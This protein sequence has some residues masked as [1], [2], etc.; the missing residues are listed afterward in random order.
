[1]KLLTKIVLKLQS[2]GAN[3]A[4]KLATYLKIAKSL[5]YL[6][7]NLL[8]ARIGLEGS[9]HLTSAFPTW[10]QLHSLVLNLDGN[11]LGIEGID[12]VCKAI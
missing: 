7:I 8:D 4:Q 11:I 9:R 3:N 5:K 1:M 10:P 2:L 6:D 12:N